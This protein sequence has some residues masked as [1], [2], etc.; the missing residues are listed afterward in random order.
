MAGLKQMVKR[1]LGA[2]PGGGRRSRR[3]DDGADPR[4]P[5]RAAPSTDI[6][7]INGCTVSYA[8]DVDGEP[9]CGE[10]V[11]T[12]VPYEEDPSQGKDRPV[13]LIGRRNG[14]LVG[15][16]LTSKGDRPEEFPVGAGVWDRDGR[17]SF[18]KLD[19]IL[20]VDPSKVRRE[21]GVL[22]RPRFD[23]LV[24]ALRSYHA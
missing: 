9:D 15:V 8:P 24:A 17:P 13:V 4:P 11:W 5:G 14:A 16:P 3:Q 10:V 20:Q 12:W 19:R 21:G 1:A 7:T 18:A 23:D 22:P 6:A 2:L